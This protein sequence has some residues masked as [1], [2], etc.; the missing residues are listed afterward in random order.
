MWSTPLE[1]LRQRFTRVTSSVA[2]IPQIDGL[3]AFALLLVIGHHVFATYLED[4]HRLGTQHLPQDWP[5]IW[6]RSSLVAWGVHLTF[7]V[8]IFFVISGFV[9][10]IPFARTLLKQDDAPSTRLYLLRRL[11]RIE[12]PYLLNMTF[13]FLLLLLSKPITPWHIDV[14]FQIFGAHYLA[15]ISYLH[16][17]IYGQPSW[18]GGVAWTLEI[19][20]QF[21]LLM[22]LIAQLFRIHHNALRRS[23]FAA[24]AACASLF[25]QYG[26]QNPRLSL[27]VLHYLGF[28]L[29]GVL[30]A[31]IYLNP[32][33]NLR[34]GQRLGDLLAFASV[35]LLIYVIHWNT[36]L[37]WLEPF[38]VAAGFLGVFHGQWTGRLFALKSLTIPGTM[39]YTA[40]LYHLFIITAFM[41]WTI[42]LF[43]QTHPLW[44]DITLQMMFMLP[45]VF[46]ISAILYLATERPFIILS[47]A[48]TRRWSSSSAEST[49]TP[50]VA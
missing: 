49:V 39:C 44:L 28:F 41:P 17:L 48:A 22:P 42:R 6:S 30:L 34:L 25:A 31:D 7:G 50:G 21:Y 9:L 29:T 5:V 23:L 4:T 20:I 1:F 43:P 47:H 19:E 35:I 16:A 26:S 18:I 27:T 14:M 37:V 2:F 33:A 46:L 24:L 11:L 45:P 15:S 13:G 38:L 40:Y 32:P 10:A 12:P 3:R 36:N 8:Q